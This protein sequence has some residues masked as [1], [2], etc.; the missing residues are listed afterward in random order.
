[1]QTNDLE[2]EQALRGE[3]LYGDNFSTEQIAQWFEDEKDGY[4]NLYYG[5]E[6]AGGPD[7]A[8]YEYAQLAEQHCYKWLP[9]REFANALGVGSA[10]GAELKPILQRSMSVTVL[11][12]SDGFASTTID[13]KSVTYV[14]PQASGLMPFKSQSFDIVVCFSVLHHIPNVSTVINEMFRVL[15]PGGYALLREP[16]HSM[17]D[18]RQ[19]R[20]GLTKRERGIPLQIFRDIIARAGFRTE[21][22]TCCMFSLIS[23]LSIFTGGKSVWTFDRIAK[24]DR[25]VCALP[26]WSRKYGAERFWHKIRPTAVS[27]VLVKP[28]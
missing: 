23:R 21:K 22:E 10:H 16:T 3:L 26:V 6:T 1:M 28:S 8:E 2:I 19:P 18:W 17:G 4:F 27:F 20:R 7:S 14:K 5:A 24:L 15:K 25:L 9:K 13:G 12:P 11:E